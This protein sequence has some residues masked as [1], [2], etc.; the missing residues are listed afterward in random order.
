VIIFLCVGFP[1]WVLFSWY[2]ELTPDGIKKTEHINP[3]ESITK[4]TG[5][6]LSNLI[7]FGLGL[8]ILLLAYNIFKISSSES[9]KRSEITSSTIENNKSIAVLA[10]A[11]MSPE[12]DQEYFSDGISEEILNLLA[13]IPDL[14]VI[15]RTSSFS[16]KGKEENIQQIGE[17]LHVSHILEG[18]IRKSGNTFRITTQLIDVKDG[19][20]LWSETY[21]REM[22]DIF[23]IQDEI[24]GKVAQQLKITLLGVISST[25]VNPEAY[26]LFLQAK[27]LAQLRNVEAH[28]SAEEL[29][30]KSIAID[31]AYAPAWALYSTIVYTGYATLGIRS[32]ENGLL[33][34]KPLS[35]RAIEL[36]PEYAMA[37]SSLADYNLTEWD[38]N[39]SLRNS[40]NALE[41][42]PENSE[43]MRK[44]AIILTYMG[45]LEDAIVLIKKSINQDPLNYISYY[46]LGLYYL[47]NGHNEEA[48]HTME[49][50]LK[51]QPNSSF[52]KGYMGE[53]L[54]R[55][56]DFKNA[57]SFIEK[58][59]DPFWKLYRK[60]KIVYAMGDHKQAD[61]LLKELISE[62]G[63]DSWPNIASIYAFRNEKDAAFKW[64]DL[65]LKNRD[66]TTLEILNYPEM[67][68]LWG[69]PRWNAYINKLGLPKDHGFHI[70]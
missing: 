61:A 55:Q 10:F 46:N 24:A 9:A 37:F 57:L 32:M 19:T 7:L 41:I 59:S 70:D 4:K 8:V 23:K 42:A 33:K 48:Q 47:W 68:N 30:K 50:Y 28:I 2:Y 51:L 11:D 52:G 44:S 69:D 31:S 5:N 25:T 35:Q 12:K 17:E 36:D 38:F 63:N 6:Q 21:E 65:A 16:Y 15:S 20:H 1:I 60:N 54:M 18:S 3:E 22:S 26:T 45:R 29:I 43:I 62:Y 58:D 53:L 67:E 40:K 66:A 64:L 49:N 39:S 56:G 14:K 13:K 27:Q 34:G